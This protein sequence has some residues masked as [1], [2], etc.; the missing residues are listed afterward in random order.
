MFKRTRISIAIGAAF[1]AGVVGY[2]PIA[3]AQDSSAEEPKKLERVEVTGSSIKRIEGETALPVQVIT[4]EDIQR[5]G[6]VNVEQLM[7]TI[8]AA[9]S[10]QALVAASASGATTLGI[11]SISLRGLSSLRTLVLINGKRITPYGYGFTNDAVSVDVNSIPVSAI[12]RVE[13]LKDGASAIYGSDAIAGVVNFIMRRDYRGAEI[14]AEYGTPKGSGGSV[15]RANGVYGIGDLS[16]DHYNAM[17]TITY[18]KEKALFGKDRK[19]ASSGINSQWNQDVTSGNTFP[20]N[21]AAADGSFGSHNPTSV[22]AGAANPCPGPYATTDPNFSPNVCRFDPSPLVSLIPDAQRIG[23]FASGKV[24][25]SPAAELY[26]EASFSR[27]KQNVVI[28]PTPLS[29]QF[30][31]PP[32]NSLVNTFPY[33][34]VGIA[35]Q[36]APASTILMTSASPFYPTAYVQSITGGAT[37]DILIRW[38]AGL[39]GNRDFTDTSESP[40]LNFGAKGT[41]GNFD[42][43]G[44]VLYSESKV[45][46]HTNNGFVIQSQV[47]PILNSGNVDFFGNGTSQA[48][49]DQLQGTEFRGDSLRTKTSLSSVY[50]KGSSELAQMAGGALALA[51]GGEFRKEKYSLSPSEEILAGDLTGYGGNFLPVDTSRNVYALFAEIDVPIV[52]NLEANAAVRYDHYQVTGNSTTPK[53]SLRYQPSQAVLLRASWGR[54]FRAPSLLDLYAPQTTGV[55]PVTSDPIRCPVTGSPQDCVTQFPDLNG[56]NPNLKP[57]K[58]RNI[59]AGFVI[60]PTNNVSFGVDWFNIRLTDA[61]NNGIDANTILQNQQQF[62]YL[63]TRAPASPADIAAGIPGPIINIDQTNLNVGEFRLEGADIDLRWGIP[64]GA[65]G[66]FTWSLNGTYFK[67]FDQQNVGGTGFTGTVDQANNATGGVVPRWKHY[68][69]LNW[70]IGPWSTTVAQNYQSNYYDLFSNLDG[71]AEPTHAVVGSYET[72][73]FQTSYS[74]VKN[75]TLTFGVKNVF[76]RDPP[77]TNA[78]GEV[79]FQAGYDPSYADPRGRFFY[80]RVNYKFF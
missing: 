36:V 42:Y 11:S 45:T 24:D 12:E 74:G 56:G 79:F 72:Y 14:S 62:G 41:I 47:L 80:G 68:L 55:T 29:D 28:Q 59:T 52:R 22:G 27:N 57:E 70:A 61:I 77:Y 65:L 21:F 33:N 32:N 49:L 30:A 48:V 66:K 13:I 67:K 40:R 5:T 34:C 35:C 54:G 15:A 44:G 8:S 3:L 10:S 1:S 69:A 38:R 2:I 63:I 43:D 39:L 58:S 60:E 25:L 37:P 31:L 78:G 50:A 18:S 75:L 4:R 71:G 7:Q 16:A 6:A 64:A 73:D 20:A 76:D 9:A 53:L 46:E 51:V 23:V 17:F 19:F 26:A